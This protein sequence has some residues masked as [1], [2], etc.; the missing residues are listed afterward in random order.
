MG[1]RYTILMSF[2]DGK[3]LVFDKIT[4]ENHIMS[5]EVFYNRKGAI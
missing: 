1:D 4:N 2:G 3:L 5:S